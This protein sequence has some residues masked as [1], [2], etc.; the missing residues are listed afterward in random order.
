MQKNPDCM[1]CMKNER[2]DSMMIEICKMD[3]S[4]AYLYKEQ[5]HRGRCNVAL[6]RHV[7]ELF[8]LSEK[9]LA[10][11]M[12]DVA[13]VA[14]AINK[15]FK[16]GKINYGAFADKLP[17][18]HF[19]IVPKYEDGANWGL[20]FEMNPG[21]VYLTDAEYKEMIEAIKKNL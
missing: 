21:K 14:A 8:D 2:L 5:T 1:Y 15:V 6:D 20:N 13:R 18:M 17:H 12:N 4:T 16:P 10:A 11:Y 9:E 19:H 7:K 3:V